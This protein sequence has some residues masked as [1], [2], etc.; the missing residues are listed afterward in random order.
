MD[1][2]IA[3][4]FVALPFLL[5][6]VYVVK[7]LQERDDEIEAYNMTDREIDELA[8]SSPGS[9]D[10]LLAAGLLSYCAYSIME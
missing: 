8:A 7:K 9:S 5:I 2:V 4:G 1:I 6:G 10:D 3:L